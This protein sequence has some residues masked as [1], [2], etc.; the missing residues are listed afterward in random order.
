[1]SEQE[2][3]FDFETFGPLPWAD[4]KRNRIRVWQDD[5][6]IHF[7]RAWIDRETGAVSDNEIRTT[8][9]P[10]DCHAYGLARAISWGCSGRMWNSRELAPLVEKVE[11][12]FTGKEVA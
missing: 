10:R 8:L 3:S 2:L 11:S 5:K 6:G 4:E 7:G 12:I 1:M 9:E